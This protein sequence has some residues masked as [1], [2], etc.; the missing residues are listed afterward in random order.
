MAIIVVGTGLAS[1]PASQ[2]MNK[3]GTYGPTSSSPTLLPVWTPDPA[4]SGTNIVADQLV[5]DRAGIIDITSRMVVTANSLGGTVTGYIY[6][7]NASIKSASSNTVSTINL[8]ITGIVVAQGDLLDM[9]V[10]NSF[11]T[12][13]IGDVGT[14]LQFIAA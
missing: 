2:R 12:V 11:G 7:N 10:S 5:V 3:S 9:R 4:F 6:K 13:A 14:Y 1:R 8:D